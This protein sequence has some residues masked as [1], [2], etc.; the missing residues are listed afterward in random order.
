MFADAHIHLV[1]LEGRDPA[2]AARFAAGPYLACAASHDEGEFHRTVELAAAVDAARPSLPALSLSFGIHPQWAVW[3]NA[4]FLATLA[5][6]RRISAI[7]EAGFDFFGDRPER[8]RNEENERVQRDVFEFQLAL[9]ERHGL[10]M[11]LHVRKAMDR[12]FA[13][14]KRLA[15]LPA[16]VLHSYQGTAREGADLLARGANA[17]FSFGAAILN[18]HKRAIEACA[19]LP[20]DRLLS[21]T[22]APWQPP[23]GSPYCRFEAIADVVRGM[24]ALR[25]T[26]AAYLEA[27]LETNFRRAYSA[28]PLHP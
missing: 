24:A 25:G 13:A 22:D 4:D 28:A 19:L 26:D 11:V 12:V 6:G 17:Y 9:A 1:D 3:K 5:A 7:G 8:V 2:F 27:V 10:P 16:I 20:E 15:R 23:R 18:G 21:E 14:S